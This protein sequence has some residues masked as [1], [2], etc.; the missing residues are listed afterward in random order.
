MA[1]IQV[2]NE[3]MIPETYR[4]NRTQSL[5]NVESDVG[6]RFHRDFEI[7]ALDDEPEQDWNVGLVVGPSGSGKS[8]IGRLLAEQGWRLWQNLKWPKDKPLIDAILPKGDYDTVSGALAQVGLGTVPS[9]LRPYSVLSNGEQFR[10]ELA[11]VVAE[12][13]DRVV[14]D[15][16]TSVV[17]RQIARVGAMAFG[18]AWKRSGKQAVLLTCHHDV[19]DWLQPDW[20]LDTETG[21]F[22]WGWV[23]SPAQ[24]RSGD[25][26]RG[27][28]V[29]V[30]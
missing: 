12:Q 30:V 7:P 10:A 16:F 9:W 22:T 11:R 21:E 14:I 27:V 4:S 8:S 3:I 17:D 20:V 15:E 1:V 24:D 26:G 19:A 25:K 28:A 29:L 5:Y 13:P 6:T 18:K 2:R 23:Q